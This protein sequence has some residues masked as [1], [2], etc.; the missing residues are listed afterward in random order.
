VSN[1]TVASNIVVGATDGIKVGTASGATH[2]SDNIK[3]IS[4]SILGIRP[5]SFGIRVSYAGTSSGTIRNLS[6]S[7][8]TLAAG[9]FLDFSTWGIYLQVS[10]PA[11]TEVTVIATS[12]KFT[13]LAPAN[14]IYNNGNNSTVTSKGN[15]TAP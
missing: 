6:I 10:V 2:N 1:V 12:N 4:N 11:Q 14:R 13:G 7:K 8:N 9:P 3:L 15:L 5:N